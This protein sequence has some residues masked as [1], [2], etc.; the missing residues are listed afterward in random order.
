MSEQEKYNQRMQLIKQWQ[1]MGAVFSEETV[2]LEGPDIHE[3]YT[4]KLSPRKDVFHFENGL[5]FLAAIR[6]E[7]IFQPE[8]GWQNINKLEVVELDNDLNVLNVGMKKFLKRIEMGEERWLTE[9]RKFEELFSKET[10][11]KWVTHSS[12]DFVHI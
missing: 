10:K 6:Y 7:R 11:E 3:R 12:A 5:N 4:I 2:A 9:L 8:K 1:R